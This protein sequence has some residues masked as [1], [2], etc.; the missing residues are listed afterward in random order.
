MTSAETKM[1]VEALED[2]SFA[3]HY[4]DVR[5]LVRQAQSDIGVPS[6]RVSFQGTKFPHLQQQA[7]LH[8]P[9][10]AMDPLD[11]MVQSYQQEWVQVWKICNNYQSQE[12]DSDTSGLIGLKLACK[13][14]EESRSTIMHYYEQAIEYYKKEG[15]V[16][17]KMFR[18]IP[19]PQ[20]A[21]PLEIEDT[22][23]PD[24]PVV[25]LGGMTWEQSTQY[26]D[27]MVELDKKRQE[28]LEDEWLQEAAENGFAEA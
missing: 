11:H 23:F 8:V 7:H 16:Q 26:W 19:I 28:E 12:M 3:L 4:K 9:L 20:K 2:E 18:P 24:E 25:T 6:W 27:E 15:I 14:T 17:M 13:V 10:L 5:D 1:T 22:D 21:A